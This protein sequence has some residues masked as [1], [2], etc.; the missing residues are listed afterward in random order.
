MNQIPVVV[1][2]AEE[3][4]KK[5]ATEEVEAEEVFAE[6]EEI[7]V[8][9]TPA[10]ETPV[11]DPNA[12]LSL[13]Y[14]RNNAV[15]KD[16]IEESPHTGKILII[17]CD[18]VKSVV[19]RVLTIGYGRT[20]SVYIPPETLIV[21]CAVDQKIEVGPSDY[22]DKSYI[23]YNVKRITLEDIE[24]GDWVQLWMWVM[25]DQSIGIANVRKYR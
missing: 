19:D 24:P 14:F 6:V 17:P 5:I 1:Q 22:Y 13:A 2:E 25:P 3:E 4:T 15:T 18:F 20:L 8:E 7:L 16:S 21:E 23:W 10:V 9:E 11:E 12:H